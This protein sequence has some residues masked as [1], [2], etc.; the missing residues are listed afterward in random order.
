MTLYFYHV[1]VGG[2]CLH[3]EGSPEHG[4]V[5]G[6]QAVPPPVHQ[7]GPQQILV[8]GLIDNRQIDKLVI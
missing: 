8:G 2:V 5:I 3:T 7:P 6:G 1:P 4:D